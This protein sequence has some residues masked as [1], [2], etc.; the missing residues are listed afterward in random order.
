MVLT[1]T[2][3]IQIIAQILSVV[4]LFIF[5]PVNSPA[6]DVQSSAFVQQQSVQH[7]E[8][9]VS[10]QS[11]IEDRLIVNGQSYVYNKKTVIDSIDVEHPAGRIADLTR[12]SLLNLVYR[13]Y[14]QQTEAVPYPPGTKV[15]ERVTLVEKVTEDLPGTEDTVQE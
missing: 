2:Q 15:L 3:S 13:T 8:T 4:F 12:H 7:F 1:R 9:G 5:L 6:E 10:L 11:V 14:S